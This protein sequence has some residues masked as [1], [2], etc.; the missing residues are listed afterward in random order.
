LEAQIIVT[1]I[2]NELNDPKVIFTKELLEKLNLAEEKVRDIIKQARNLS[3][4]LSDVNSV[5]GND[6]SEQVFASLPKVLQ[7]AM[8]D[9][10][11]D[12]GEALKKVQIGDPNAAVAYGKVISEAFRQRQEVARLGT[13]Q[14][15][16]LQNFGVTALDDIMSALNEVTP[17]LSNFGSALK[18]LPKADLEDYFKE[19]L[20]VQEIAEL[21]NTGQAPQQALEQAQNDLLKVT[22]FFLELSQVGAGI[23]HALSTLDINLEPGEINFLDQVERDVIRQSV[24]EIRQLELDLKNASTDASRKLIQNQIDGAM[25]VLEHDVDRYTYDLFRASLDAGRKF[26]DAVNSGLNSALVETITEGRDLESIFLKMSNAI[27]KS[28]VQA[29]VDG[30]LDPL[31]G[32]AGFFTKYLKIA[33][34]KIFQFGAAIFTKIIG[35]FT[36]PKQ[37]IQGPVKPPEIGEIETVTDVGGDFKK[38]LDNYNVRETY[39]NKYLLGELKTF[40][41][42]PEMRSVFCCDMTDMPGKIGD[43]VG[44][45]IVAATDGLDGIVDGIDKIKDVSILNSNKEVNGLDEVDKS[46]TDG[47]NSTIR[48]LSGVG[49]QIVGAV[50]G[51]AEANKPAGPD[52]LDKASQA[53]QIVTFATASTG[54]LI[55]GSGTDTSDSIHAMLSN[56][57]FVVNAKATRKHLS[58][59][60][61]IN[62]DSIPGF[63]SGGLVGTPSINSSNELSKE[64]YRVSGGNTE[65]VFNINITGDVSRQTRAQVISMI[66]QIA[67]GVNRHNHEKLGHNRRR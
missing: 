30:L 3:E 19:V 11:D 35:A 9:S 45:K 58:L 36:K 49:N 40:F 20:K 44:M 17:S 63:A 62:D 61:A 1:R 66:P 29:F 24:R 37:P 67:G 56:N 7:E 6:V 50:I 22:E 14:Q 5:F 55:K 16:Q 60:K 15:V 27:K 54:G 53:I 59:L 57:E 28:M 23:T 33:G 26:A 4:V 43:E 47:F 31:T 13:V 52:F 10:A 38:V 2:K 34:Q 25:F 42:G 18:S 39:G 8:R 21:V 48:T 46:I 41:M 65:Q 32:Q 64:R 12:L 51:A